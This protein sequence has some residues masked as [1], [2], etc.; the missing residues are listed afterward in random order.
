M[1]VVEEKDDGRW[2]AIFKYEKIKILYFIWI[3]KILY[4]AFFFFKCCIS[5]FNFLFCK[6]NELFLLK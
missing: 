6:I 5:Q 4:M 3:K 2:V 1:I